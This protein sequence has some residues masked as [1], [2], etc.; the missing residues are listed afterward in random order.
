M[1]KLNQI[2]L[3]GT[4]AKDAVMKDISNGNQ[5]A[6]VRVATERYYRNAKG[7]S[8]KEVSYF[9]VEGWGS[10]SSLCERKCKEGNEIRVVGRLKQERWKDGDGKNCSRVYIIAEH[11]DFPPHEEEGKSR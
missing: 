8:V 2:I 9:D 5:I 7:E 3:E 11:I 10:Y 1:S 6:V 4:C